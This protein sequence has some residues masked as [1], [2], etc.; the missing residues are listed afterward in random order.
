MS[1]VTGIKMKFQVGSFFAAYNTLCS[2]YFQSDNQKYLT[3]MIVNGAFT[4]ELA[5]KAILHETQIDFG[6][7]HNLM[8]LFKLLPEDI[9]LDIINR[10]MAKAEPYRNITEWINQLFAIA[11]DFETWR[12][13]AEA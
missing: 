7:E 6:K 9:A 12:Y 3:P 8:Y 4:A 5:I 2:I 10:S 13:S 1:D 11:Q